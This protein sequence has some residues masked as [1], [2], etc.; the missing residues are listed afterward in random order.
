MCRS[1]RDDGITI[2][3][4]LPKACR[5]G[6]HPGAARRGIGSWGGSS[7]DL[8]DLVTR[9]IAG[10]DPEVVAPGVY[11]FATDV[12]DVVS[13]VVDASELRVVEGPHDGAQC[14]ATASVE[15]W[16]AIVGSDTPTDLMQAFHYGKLE[17]SNLRFA[18]Y[19]RALM[20]IEQPR[21]ESADDDARNARHAT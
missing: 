5:I 14:R 18:P 10:K 11:E 7:V 12:G 21:Q 4:S 1:Q 2:D 16:E 20:L 15:D 3:E 8:L 9:S 17:I 13:I 19:L 6:S